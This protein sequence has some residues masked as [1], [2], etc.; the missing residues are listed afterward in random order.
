VQLVLRVAQK[1]GVIL[2]PNCLQDIAE[3]PLLSAKQSQVATGL[4]PKTAKLPPIVLDFH[5]Q[6]FFWRNTLPIYHA[7]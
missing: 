5:S 3:H 7:H 4:Q 1:N 2:K 6:P